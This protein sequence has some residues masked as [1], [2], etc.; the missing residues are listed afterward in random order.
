MLSGF[1]IGC[2]VC[3]HCGAAKGFPLPVSIH[4]APGAGWLAGV[5]YSLYLS[6]KIAFH[7]LQT[8]LASSLREHALLAFAI[9]ALA[10]LLLGATL[11]YLVE[12]PCLK[13]RE[14]RLQRA[15][16]VV[17]LAVDESR[18]VPQSA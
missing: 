17:D 1:L 16:S 4:D 9:Y 12:W 13:L 15:A 6:H 11:H 3:G 18:P 14:R 10:A 8:T 7:L 2:Q 5:S